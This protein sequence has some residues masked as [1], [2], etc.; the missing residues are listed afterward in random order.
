ML[1]NTMYD[2]RSGDKRRIGLPK[3]GANMVGVVNAQSSIK[4]IPCLGPSQLTKHSKFEPAKLEQWEYIFSLARFHFEADLIDHQKFLERLLV[5]MNHMH[6]PK[7]PRREPLP[8]CLCYMFVRMILGFVPYMTEKQ[9]NIFWKLCTLN[10]RIL[11]WTGKKDCINCKNRRGP[12]QACTACSEDPQS[13]PAFVPFSRVLQDGVRFVQEVIPPSTFRAWE[14]Q[15]G[16]SGLRTGPPLLTLNLHEA[17]P[18]A[19]ER[20]ALQFPLASALSDPPRESNDGY[21]VR[22][23]RKR[24]R[25]AVRIHAN[26]G[27]GRGP[28][29]RRTRET[30]I[31]TPGPT[32]P[33]ALTTPGPGSYGDPAPSPAGDQQQS[34]GLT[35]WTKF[36]LIGNTESLHELLRSAK[37]VKKPGS[38]H[39]TLN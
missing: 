11:Y 25:G 9:L 22:S 33:A 23:S 34:A 30:S 28:A 15:T 14:R 16:R 36:Q 31:E 35:P 20:A 5:E 38:L 19:A 29:L 18:D 2:V 17:T 24:R 7:D 21:S 1:L 4:A 26:S 8:M 13:D 3:R 39:R 27:L 32:T 12:P 37:K 6:R 10:L